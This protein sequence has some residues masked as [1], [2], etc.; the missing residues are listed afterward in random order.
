M[1]TGKK[2]LLATGFLSLAVSLI[3]MVHSVDARVPNLA[4][5]AKK[6]VVAVYVDDRKGAHIV[7]ATGIIVDERGIVATSCY[8][9]PKW[10]EKVENSLKV[11]TEKGS[12]FP[13]ENL[14]SENCRNNIVLVQIR[15]KGLPAV[16]LAADR[17][18]KTGEEVALVTMAGPAAGVKAARIKAVNRKNGFSRLS[19]PITVARDGSPV[20]DK[21]G[22]VIGVATFL[23]AKKQNQ[24]AV[25]PARQI[26]KEFARLK[27]LIEKLL[28]SP[29][30]P[31]ASPER[32]LPE[33][34]VPSLTKEQR[35][36][37]YLT[38]ES[39]F[40]AGS[41]Y[42]KARRYREA[43]EAY[44]RAVKMKSDYGEAYV[45]LGVAYYKLERYAEA[46]EAYKKAI[47]IQ[48]GN[49][50]VYD[51]LGATYV[52][53]GEYAKALDAFRQSIRLDPKNAETHFN[54]GVAS[55]L[56]GDKDS[57]VQEYFIL[58]ELDR[59][60]AEHLLKLIY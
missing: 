11:E 42:D 20:L 48:A 56:A 31:P 12:S 25:I 14:L 45:N 39:A 19:A 43:I 37:K 3:V 36:G 35:E 23:P 52:I 15:G 49:H 6:G 8:V 58:K 4:P 28:L 59:K 46:V 38:A 41:A 1:R 47:T 24:P 7:S 53:L 10:L 32:E 44:S 30:A 54:L 5:A 22:E 50:S 26:E 34:L 17:V 13:V 27:A 9:I 16:K 55:V 40:Q 21:K 18:P 57:A 51:K 33:A 2:A 60:S 29:S